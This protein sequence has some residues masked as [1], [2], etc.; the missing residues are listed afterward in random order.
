MEIEFEEKWKLFLPKGEFKTSRKYGWREDRKS[1]DIFAIHFNSGVSVYFKTY[2]KKA[3]ALQ[4]STVDAMFADEEMPIALMD[5]LMFRLVASSGYF[6][7]V[8]TATLGQEFWRLTMDPGPAEPENWPEA[9]K[10]QVS[11]YDCLYYDDGT[12]SFWTVER[13]KEIENTCKDEHEIARRVHGKFVLSKEG[14]LYPSFNSKKHVKEKHPLP[15]TWLIFSAVD[16]GS[17]GETNHP[18]AIM[19]IGVNPEYTK[20]RVFL[21]WRGDGITTTAGD[22]LEKYKELKHEHKIR[23]V[24]EIYDWASVDFGIMAARAGEPFVKAEKKHELGEDILNTLF[25]KDMLEI[26]HDEETAKLVTEFLGLRRGVDKRK[27]KD[28]LVD[29]ARYICTKIPWDWSSVTR[30]EAAKRVVEPDISDIERQIL[31]RRGELDDE[32]AER[33]RQ[34]EDIESEFAEWNENYG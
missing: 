1:G 31:D 26:Y 28:D 24:L 18:A 10:Q 25:K 22:I 29:T 6:S 20:G 32:E 33:R 11:M 27:C 21:A 8:F 7:M 13:I 3:S 9:Y 19:F 15:K 14:L 5:E 17:G 34:Q 2:S 30:D 16:V 23:P 4:S 12:P